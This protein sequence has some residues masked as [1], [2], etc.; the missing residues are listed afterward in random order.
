VNIVAVRLLR[1]FSEIHPNAEQHLE[2]WV[3][4]TKKSIWTQPSE[5]KQRYRSA[6]I[7]KN[8]RV[9]FDIQGND[10]RLVV[11]V[12]YRY[13]AV[14]VKFIGTHKEYDDIDADHDPEAP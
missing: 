12:A 6:S 4:E 3:A 10:F 9:V 5:I 2:S 1:T 11:S 13:Q 8:R 7:L 14:H